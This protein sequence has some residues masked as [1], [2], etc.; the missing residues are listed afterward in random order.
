[1]STSILGSKIEIKDK[2]LC[3]HAGSLDQ[4]SANEG[5]LFLLFYFCLFSTDLTPRFFAIDNVDASLNPKLCA[6]LVRE[7]V[8]LASSNEKQVILATHNPAPRDGVTLDDDEQR[9]FVISGG[10]EGETEIR[11]IKQKD[12]SAADVKLS[13]AFING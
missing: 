7:M 6:H 2:S 12:G 13:N 1:D 11:R 9:L 5:F 4:I 8:K 3:E 10:D